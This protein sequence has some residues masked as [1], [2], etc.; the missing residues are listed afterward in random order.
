MAE[1]T[2]ARRFYLL[3]YH[4]LT[5]L[6]SFGLASVYLTYQEGQFGGTVLPNTFPAYAKL[7]ASKYFAK[8]DLDGADVSELRRFAKL[9]KGEAEAALAAFSTL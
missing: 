5:F 2:S 9:S 4:E 7:T 1:A 8:N 6:Q 3:K